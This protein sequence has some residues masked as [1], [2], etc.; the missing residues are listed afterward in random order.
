VLTIDDQ[1]TLSSLIATVMKKQLHHFAVTED[2]T[3]S[4]PVT[5]IV[6]EH[7]ILKTQG[8]HP[9]VILA[10]IAKAQNRQRGYEADDRQYRYDEDLQK[11]DRYKFPVRPQVHESAVDR[12]DCRKSHGSKGSDAMFLHL[13]LAPKILDFDLDRSRHLVETTQ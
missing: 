2:G 12:I 6:A 3:A 4:T 13:D 5:G 11:L 8:S 9:T 7:D 10:E 1:T